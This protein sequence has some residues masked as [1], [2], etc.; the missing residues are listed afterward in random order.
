MVLGMLTLLALGPGVLG[1]DSLWVYHFF[2]PLCHQLPERSFSV[3]EYQMAV[4]SRCLGIYAALFAGWLAMPVFGKIGLMKQDLLKKIF[5]I[6]VA[7]NLIDI[8]GNY[9]ELWS[10]TL[11]SRLFL[12]SFF[13]FS[14]AI[15]LNTEFFNKRKDREYGSTC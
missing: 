15:L 6:A 11:T 4:C 8:A 1:S 12:G 10:N 2:D 9:F 7:L 13:G 5:S 14:I 3:H